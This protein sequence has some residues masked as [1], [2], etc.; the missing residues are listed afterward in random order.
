MMYRPFQYAF[1]LRFKI[2]VV[3]VALTDSSLRESLK[4]CLFMD[5]LVTFDR[6]SQDI[7]LERL[8]RLGVGATVL[9]W[10]SSYFIS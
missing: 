6:V 4:E 8:D 3:F 1:R 7:H 10:F 2:E 5:G 9:H